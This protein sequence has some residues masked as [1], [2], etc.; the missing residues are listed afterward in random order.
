[1]SMFSRMFGRRRS[2]AE[3]EA[4]NPAVEATEEQPDEVNNDGFC[5]IGDT[6]QN[7]AVFGPPPGYTLG[8]AAAF[9]PY[10]ISPTPTTRSE[11]QSAI[12]D[13]PFKLGSKIILEGSIQYIDLSSTAGMIEKINMFNWDDYEYDFQLE[14]SILQEFNTTEHE[15]PAE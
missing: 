8:G 5:L 6:S 4:P 7:G 3:D 10:N 15:N 12:D 14:R 13:V 11:P 9:L 2:P 1:M